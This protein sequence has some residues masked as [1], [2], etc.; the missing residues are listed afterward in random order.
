[1]R[2]PTRLLPILAAVLFACVVTPAQDPDDDWAQQLQ[3]AQQ[4]LRSGNLSAA[5]SLF[6]DILAAAEEE[7]QE[8]A[9][10]AE[11]VEAAQAGIWQVELRRGRYEAV[12]AAVEALPAARRELR[13]QRLLAA[14]A[15]QAIGRHEEAARLLR[16]QRD[17]DPD[18]MEARYLLGL[19]LHEGGRRKEARAEWE[20]ALAQP[21]PATPAGLAFL[22][23]CR[24]RLG[25]RENLEASSQLLAEALQQQ[26]DQ[27]EARAT[28]GVLKFEAYGEARGFPS[29]ERDL[30]KVLEE[31]GDVEEALL[32]LYR[33]RRSNFTLDPARTE[34]L[35][36]RAL[37]QNPRSVPALVIQGEGVLDDRRF[38]EA[39]EVL[40]EALKVN[41]NHRIALAHRAAAALVLNDVRGY[42]S[43]RARALEG[44]SPWGE[45]DRI[46]GDHLVAL[47]R[48]AD[49]QPFYQ[50]ALD[51]EPDSVQALHGM[52]KAMVYCGDGA[53]AKDLLV[54]AKALEPGLVNPWRNNMLAVQELLEE[55][56]TAVENES[57][58]LLLHRDDAEVLADYL[59]PVHL[60]ALEVLGA[61]YNHRPQRRVQVETFH[62]WDDFSVRTVGFRG[63]TA[64]G[65]CFGPFITL[66]S[67]GDRD[68][69]SQEFMWEATVWHEFAHVLTLGVSRHRVPRWLTEGFSVHEE[70][71]RDVS[72][73][74]GMDRELLDAFHN[75]DIP[76]VRLLNRL[77]RGPRI[78]FGYY[79]GGLIVDLITR[80]FGFDKAVALLEAFGKDLETEDA[81]REA[82]GIGTAEFDRRFL[83]YVAEE[84][85]RGLL[86]V[87]RWNEAAM[88]RLQL[89]VAK[90]PADMVARTNLAW[91]FLQAENPVD[92]GRQL[93]AV[94]E[95]EPRNGSA[96][97]ARAAL[98][99][100]R[101]EV[102]AA[103][104]GWQQGFAAGA[105]D[106]DSRIACGRVLEQKGN[107][108][109][110]EAMYRAAMKCWP[111]CTEQEVAPELLLGRLLREQGRAA[112]ALELLRGY[113]SRTGRAY[114]PRIQ[115]ATAA[116]A[117]GNREEE[118]RWLTECNR[119]DPFS[120][121]LHVKMGEAL[122]ALGRKAEAAREYTVAA[123]VLAE[124]D[125][126]RVLGRGPAEP[127][128]PA[129][130]AAA[131]AEL[132]V[133][134]AVLHEAL[135]DKDA[136]R[137]LWE[138]VLRDAADS[139]SAAEA[140]ARLGR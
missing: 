3:Q 50:A 90:N 100:R 4:K 43:F 60:A 22:G 19:A 110:A 82:L 92:A 113:C 73:E 31:Y 23:R 83:R 1:M 70:K 54:R 80:D 115:L 97:L 20:A 123:A 87:P 56:Y 29:G 33:I 14:A 86:L 117:E 53:S 122:E 114:A 116:R 62:T 59:M 126:T 133:R 101:G 17:A 21:K 10:G 46:L 42:E 32:T 71:V 118:L 28:L 5:V 16:S 103:L 40:D 35:L 7:P 15:C 79:Q 140:R 78:L 74:R 88:E 72:W 112:E 120:R 36:E 119:I 84:R 81:F 138:R 96:L 132:W 25:G 2:F 137:T 131:R 127:E 139:P 106:F 125:R 66:V 107:A 105:D 37:A 52:A 130:D 26:P 27:A 57:F 11:L 13:E 65:A 95:Q 135:G 68:V 128:D 104:E 6:D 94:L 61:K 89:Q 93:A 121:E 34:Q 44:D 124:L 134:A 69:R 129:A 41:P 111:N 8:S 67:P 99:V 24:W 38:P 51:A 108:R 18:D 47:Y 45:V 109:G 9:P 58:R 77:F 75:R 49:A 102:D 12:L 91:G 48:F 85:L 30:R 76:P 39:A 98:L 55:Q 64:L 136:A 63:F